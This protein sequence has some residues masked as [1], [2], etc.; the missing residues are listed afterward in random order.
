MPDV[1]GLA[2][3]IRTLAVRGAP[4]IGV[5]AAWGLALSWDLSRRAGR[6]AAGALARLREDRALLA[7]TRPT[8][9]NLFWALDRQA[10]LAER[11]AAAGAD[12]GQVGEA[13]A[14]AAVEL[15]EQDVARSRALGAAG[16]AL[17]PDPATVLTHCN[18]GGLATGGYGTALGVVAPPPTPAS[19]MLRRQTRP[20]CR[21]PPHGL[22][23]AGPRDPVT[24]ICE[25]GRQPAARGGID[26]V[27]TGADRIARNGDVANKIGTYPGRAGRTRGAVLRGGA[28]VDL[29]PGVAGRE[30][31]RRRGARSVGNS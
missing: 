26:A 17:L 1:P 4:A 24:L 16:A 14:A 19:A 29:R 12:V 15:R 6:D 30:R 22:G 18:A 28:H 20:C 25:G 23:A 31:D 5:A 13:L 10:A 7:A 8:A 2:E 21:S 9:V 27:I 11:L 3:A